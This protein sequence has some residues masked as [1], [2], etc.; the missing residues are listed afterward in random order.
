MFLKADLG[1]LEQP[2]QSNAAEAFSA[3]M[4]TEKG[5][6]TKGSDSSDDEEEETLL[7]Q[8]LTC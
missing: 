6:D 8:T 4:K 3:A 1:M 7:Q 5:S 2:K